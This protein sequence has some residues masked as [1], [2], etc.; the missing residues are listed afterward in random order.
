MFTKTQF[1]FGRGELSWIPK[2]IVRFVI[3]CVWFHLIPVYVTRILQG[4]CHWHIISLAYNITCTSPRD[5]CVIGPS[6][7]I[8]DW[9]VVIKLPYIELTFTTEIF[10]R[11]VSGLMT[12]FPLPFGA[13]GVPLSAVSIFWW[14]Y[15]KDLVCN[16]KIVE[17]RVS[18]LQVFMG[19]PSFD[20]C[21]FYTDDVG[22]E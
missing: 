21:I 3:W 18:I 13:V 9:P 12:G 14:S 15:L 8:L 6:M 16:L 1:V 11:G 10:C 4:L 2:G 20:K 5:V 17:H 22:S 19:W 7:R